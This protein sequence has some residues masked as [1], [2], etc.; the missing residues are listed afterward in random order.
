MWEVA[1][2]KSQVTGGVCESGARRE[3][4]QASTGF[5]EQEIGRRSGQV[6]FT[7]PAFW[8]SILFPAKHLPPRKL[9]AFSGNYQYFTKK[10]G[11]T[12]KKRKKSCDLDILLCCLVAVVVRLPHDP[13]DVSD[14]QLGLYLRL[15]CG[16]ACTPKRGVGGGRWRT[17]WE[18]K[19]SGHYSS[20][21][22]QAGHNCAMQPQGISRGAWRNPLFFSIQFTPV[23][24]SLFQRWLAK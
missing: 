19:S 15:Y 5:S 24:F 12:E 10:R 20:G 6:F 13:V 3:G 2:S 1:P 18:E 11:L 16:P 7:K 4:P 8:Q 14:W 23:G 17:P 22:P 9:A 21:R